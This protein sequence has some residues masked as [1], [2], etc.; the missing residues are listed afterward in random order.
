MKVKKIIT[1]FAVCV[2]SIAT[3]S[4]A[5]MAET[6]VPYATNY[7][8]ADYS[9]P[10]GDIWNGKYETYAWKLDGTSTVFCVSI[11]SNHEARV[12]AKLMRQLDFAKD[13]V[14]RTVELSGSNGD[15]KCSGSYTP[16]A[17]NNYYA[18]V[19]CLTFDG[20]D[21]SVSVNAA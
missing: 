16:I 9:A 20:A 6:V 11:N 3:F 14:A 5:A 18:T 1:V 13:V 10:Y 21:G 8:Y 4:M 17:G 12:I 2:L 15:W 7:Q 19:E